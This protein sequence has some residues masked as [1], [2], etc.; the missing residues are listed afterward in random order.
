MRLIFINNIIDKNVIISW[1]NKE[2]I[3]KCFESLN[4]L[5]HYHLL[6]PFD[7]NKQEIQIKEYDNENIYYLKLHQEFQ[8]QLIVYY[9]I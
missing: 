9:I 2:S 8:K 7:F 6:I 3:N 1:F 5:I 4:E